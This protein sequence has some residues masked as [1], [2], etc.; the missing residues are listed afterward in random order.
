MSLG[1]RVAFNL[2]L[3][4]AARGLGLAISAV[5][6]AIL[7]RRLGPEA[8][9]Q[10]TYAVV[11]VTI[12]T[13]FTDHGLNL[14]IVRRLAANPE[15]LPRVFG[16]ALVLKA[17]TGTGA[18][19]LAVLL[20][21]L[22]PLPAGAAPAI[23]IAAGLVLTTSLTVANGVFQVRLRMAPV[24]LADVLSRGAFLAAALVLLARGGG[25]RS[26]LAA[27]VVTTGL[28]TAALVLMAARLVRPRFAPDWR[29][30]REVVR[31]A[32][33][34]TLSL[35]LGMVYQRLDLFLVEHFRGAAAAGHYAAAFRIV[36]LG[37]LIPGLTMVVV[38]PVFAERFRGGREALAAV[39]RPVLDV[40]ALAGL[41]LAL[42]LAFRSRDILALVAGAAFVEAGPA[43]ALLGWG[44]AA[45]F[46][47][48]AYG[49]LLVAA[50]L[51]RFNLGLALAGLAT[52]VTLNLAL[53]PVYGLIGGG[54]AS[55]G[56][57]VVVLLLAGAVVARRVGVPVW[58]PAWKE[59]A[60]LA[61]GLALLL[62]GLGQLGLAL[63]PT[64]G[65]Y[66]IALAA[67][68]AGHPRW[69]SE[70]ASMV[71]TRRAARP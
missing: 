16:N 42:L 10:Y 18:A 25:V 2:G 70:V 53:I 3:I 12:F 46:L 7:A 23:A 6:F 45:I 4:T 50:G 29:L 5:T 1:R 44:M 54:W 8:F 60:G 27:Q 13:A 57:Q 48:N 37:I 41:S 55:I 26:I 34:L 59:L 61:A 38:F 67:F 20:G 35:V 65:V 9:G 62:A 33:P 32:I 63:L 52:S 28:S 31:P 14:P 58:P 17:L 40:M 39:T 36:D 43:L 69:R 47:S 51:E 30:W 64:I 71:S 21:W 66:G 15:D 19:L 11:F 24:A 22:L 68:L 49:Y 56:T